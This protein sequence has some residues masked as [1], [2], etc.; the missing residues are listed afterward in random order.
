MPSVVFRSVFTPR[1]GDGITA[2]HGQ[3]GPPAM[4]RRQLLFVAF[5]T[6]GLTT[7]A[8]VRPGKAVHAGTPTDA[9]TAG[10]GAN[11]ED[12]ATHRWATSQ[13][14]HWRQLMIQR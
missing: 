9:L 4:T 12:T 2:D 6:A 5:L 10:Y 13:A 8:V 11:D 14:R 1:A 7:W 3:G